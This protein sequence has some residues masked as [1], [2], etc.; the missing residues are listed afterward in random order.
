MPSALFQHTRRISFGWLLGLLLALPLAQTAAT[1]H[2]LSHL[3]GSAEEVGE[4]GKWPEPASHDGNS[5]PHHGACSLCLM[6]AAIGAGGLPAMAPVLPFVV[7][8]IR[9]A[10]IFAVETAARAVPPAA[11]YRSRAPP[12]AAA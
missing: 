11:A 2:E 3:G 5:L 8:D 12:R 4:S 6:A 9:L 7:P 10:R 1:W